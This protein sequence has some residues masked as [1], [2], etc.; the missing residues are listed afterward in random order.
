VPI[1]VVQNNLGHA[2][3]THRPLGVDAGQ[4]LLDER[5]LTPGIDTMTR[6]T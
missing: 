5:S 2:G 6:T 3:F 1:Q 4:H